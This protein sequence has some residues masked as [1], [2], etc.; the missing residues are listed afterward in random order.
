MIRSLLSASA[1]SEVEGE[2]Q[3]KFTAALEPK[4]EKG[5]VLTMAWGNLKWTSDFTVMP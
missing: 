4:G 5:G 1:V 2:P 3:T